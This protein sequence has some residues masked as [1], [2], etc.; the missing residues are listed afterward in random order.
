M[1]PED[2]KPNCL[3]GHLLSLIL[4]ALLLVTTC[5]AQNLTYVGTQ[6][7]AVARAKAEGKMI[8][9]DFGRTNCSDCSGMMSRFQLLAPP[10]KQWILASCVWWE[11]DIDTNSEYEP[12]AEGMRGSTL[13]I[14][15][16]VDPEKTGT[17]TARYNGLIGASTM[18][19]YIESAA[20]TNLPLVVDNLPGVSLT[21]ASFT[22]TGLARTNAALSGSISNEA[23]LAV[24]WR[25]NGTGPFQPATGTT[26]WSA[27]VSLLHG[28][29]TFQSYV[30]YARSKNSWTNSVTLINLGAGGTILLPQTITFIPLPDHVYGDASFDLSPSASGGGSASPVTFTATGPAFISGTTL[31]ITGA[32]MVT[33]TAN[34]AGDGVTYSAASP[35]S[36]SFTVSKAELTVTANNASKVVGATNPV[37]TASYF[38]FVS[39]D[40]TSAIHGSPSLTTAATSASSAGLYTIVATNGTLN[41]TNYGFSFVNGMLTITNLSR[42]VSFAALTNLLGNGIVDQLDLNVF[43][44][45]YWSQSPPYITNTTFPGLTN[46]NFN[47]TNFSFKV[48]F[49][50]DLQHWTNLNSPAMISFTDTNAVNVPLRYYRLLALTNFNQ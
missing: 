45:H 13:P 32:G 4:G 43:L 36:R 19:D 25:L 29:N 3:W 8:L 49:S 39:P 37:F 38:G 12:Y 34:Q 16:F 26:K 28:T 7:Q 6:A 14:L 35:V 40:T 30:Q 24:M 10:L 15:C 20:V 47:I 31:S 41:A 2:S 33:V 5:A 18:L 22:V 42:I 27:Q 50:A 21:N 9:A 11:M 48:Q 46:L 1:Q 23:I 44:A 17:W